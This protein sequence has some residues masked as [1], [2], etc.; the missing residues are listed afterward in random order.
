MDF[1]KEDNNA[2]LTHLPRTYS[3]ESDL[4]M[5]A[6]ASD[7]EGYRLAAPQRLALHIEEYRRR[8]V[9]ALQKNK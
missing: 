1:A 5:I 3:D 8:L 4:F 7:Q 6:L 2:Y 9:E